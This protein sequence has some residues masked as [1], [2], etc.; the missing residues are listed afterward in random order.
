MS[1]EI[2]KIKTEPDVTNYSL[3]SLSSAISL[4]ASGKSL[5]LFFLLI[6]VNKKVEF[7]YRKK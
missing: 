4:H 2:Q 6:E 5:C 1:T 3:P 7:E